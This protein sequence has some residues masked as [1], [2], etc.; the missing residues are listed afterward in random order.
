M[1]QFQVTVST[2]VDANSA[3]DAR[4]LVEGTIREGQRAGYVGT[5]T[6]VVSVDAYVAPRTYTQEEFDAAVLAAAESARQ[7]ALSGRLEG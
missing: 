1:S 7:D 5:D 6:T 3:Q 4:T 2:V